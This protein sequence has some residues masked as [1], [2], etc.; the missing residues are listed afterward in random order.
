VKIE[1]AGKQKELP[2]L[3]SDISET[4]PENRVP[5]KKGFRVFQYLNKFP[6]YFGYIYEFE[7]DGYLAAMANCSLDLQLDGIGYG[8]FDILLKDDL[9]AA[10]LS[11]NVVDI[12]IHRF[13]DNYAINRHLYEKTQNEYQVDRVVVSY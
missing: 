6:L 8:E 4:L 12:T 11:K 3:L 9:G 2:K 10:I 13:V 7:T 1:L 5:I